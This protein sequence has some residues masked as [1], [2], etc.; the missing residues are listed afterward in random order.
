[1]LAAISCLRESPRDGAEETVTGGW[2]ENF[3]APR[4]PTAAARRDFVIILLRSKLAN[5]LKLLAGEDA[6]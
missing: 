6:R 2:K 5:A 3:Q 4:I 1:V